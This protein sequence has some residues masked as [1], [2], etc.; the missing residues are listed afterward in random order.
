MREFHIREDP[1]NAFTTRQDI[2]FRDASMLGADGKY[3]LGALRAYLRRDKP[4]GPWAVVIRSKRTSE[5]TRRFFETV[6]VLP[7]GTSFEDAKEAVL[8]FLRLGMDLEP[9]HAE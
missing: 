1:N 6:A 8:N 7:E 5:P 2:D 4:S 3:K 9:G